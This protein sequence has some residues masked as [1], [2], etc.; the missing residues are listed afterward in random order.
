MKNKYNN[1]RR[2]FLAAGSLASLGLL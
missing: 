1:S 2:Q